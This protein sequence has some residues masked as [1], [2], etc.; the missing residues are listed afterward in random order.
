MISKGATKQARTPADGAER[1]AFGPPASPAPEADPMAS[2]R[3]E[4]ATKAKERA[5]ASTERVRKHREKKRSEQEQA[6]DAEALEREAAEC[7]AVFAVIYDL[8][9]VP[10]VK[11]RL[12][13]LDA[14]QATR[15]GRAL[16][17]LVRKYAPLLGEYQAEVTA[18]LVLGS[19]FRSNWREP[20]QE[21]AD[22]QAETQGD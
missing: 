19:I 6:Q 17:P 9:L 7:G 8:A 20:I 13:P 11:G 22:G 14:E 4:R 10:M 2:E 18:V 15:A 1:E 21:V 12:G 16:V 5:G 3:T